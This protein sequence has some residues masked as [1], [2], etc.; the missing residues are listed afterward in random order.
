M[1]LFHCTKDASTALSTTR[2]GVNHSWVFGLVLVDEGHYSPA[3]A[4]AAFIC[5]MPNACHFLLPARGREASLVAEK[6]SHSV[7]AYSQLP[8]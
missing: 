6:I 2:N 3:K 5:A 8:G 1:L 7:L 4:W